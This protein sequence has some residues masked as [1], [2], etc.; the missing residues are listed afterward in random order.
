MN[1]KTS[2]IN[3]VFLFFLTICSIV[4]TSIALP[5]PAPGALA[6]AP[7]SLMGHTYS[8]VA[9]DDTPIVRTPEVDFDNEPL[10]R[11]IKFMLKTKSRRS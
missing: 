3:T 4:T 2:M 1:T 9:H 8:Y 7:A 5:A 11:A 10:L 6:D